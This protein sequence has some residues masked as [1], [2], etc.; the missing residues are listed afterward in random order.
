MSVR[1]FVP[2][3]F[4]VAVWCLARVTVSVIELDYTETQYASVMEVAQIKTMKSD[5]VRKH[6]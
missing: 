1:Q 4:T 5:H 3:Y 6:R 2:F